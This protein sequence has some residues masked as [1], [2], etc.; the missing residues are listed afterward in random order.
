M[1][2]LT[3]FI[4]GLCLAATPSLAEPDAAV[5]QVADV[6]VDVTSGNA[7]IARDLAI[8]Q[9]E[10]H[11]FDMLME[12]LGA[13]EQ[14]KK[15]SDD[16][17]ASMVQAI[18]IQKET[19]YGMRY[20]GT[21]SVQ[22]KP[23]K[24][25]TYLNNKGVSYIEVRSSPIVV[26]PI[27]HNK[28]RDILWEEV[29]PWQ[30][31]WINV[32]KK[33]G[34]VPTIV[35][36][37]EADDVAKIGAPE[38]LAGKTDN[39]LAIM[40]KYEATGILVAVLQGDLE[41]FDSKSESVIDLYRYDGQGKPADPVHMKLPPFTS[42]KDMTEALDTTVHR[43]IGQIERGW[44]Q[45]N[46]AASGPSTFLPVDVAV[47]TLAA[48]AQIRNKLKLVTPIAGAHVVTMTRGLVHAEIE[49]HGDVP[50]LQQALTQQG[51]V[52]EQNAGG[53]WDLSDQA[54]TPTY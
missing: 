3:L 31:A 9:A 49:F 30:T 37:A 45:S 39:L 6:L 33:A 35:P 20:M 18:E 25:R 17:I 5:Y 34:L 40:K 11:A 52:L 42:T 15:V 32:A 7:S 23:D 14:M 10:R 16:A 53:G 1:R 48:W 43:L 29:T 13:Q 24:V 4:L 51:L 2:L 8:M 46:K 28:G 54:R 38:A 27:L 21:F 12:R 36:E 44:R 19:A 50:A 47:P 26:L 22:F 41:N